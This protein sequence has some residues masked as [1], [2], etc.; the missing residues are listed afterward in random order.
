MRAG[1]AAARKAHTSS[2]DSVERKGRLLTTDIGILPARRGLEGEVVGQRR[3]SNWPPPPAR[4][5]RDRQCN[6]VGHTV[7]EQG[8]SSL[9]SYL[10][11]CGRKS[12]GRQR[13]S[14]WL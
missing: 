4:Q 6:T 11:H 1:P 10:S 5:V 8:R 12:A 13:V 7:Q 9:P 14:T 3:A 2:K